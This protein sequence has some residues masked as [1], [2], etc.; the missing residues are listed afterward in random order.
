MLPRGLYAIADV[1]CITR[2]R[3]E[4]IPFVRALLEARPA[5]LQVRA[6][7]LGARDYLALL[8]TVVPLAKA[9][10]VTL[11]ANDRPDLAWL[12]GCDGVH[13]GQTDLPV[14]A[15]RRLPGHL[16]VGVSTHD[17]SQ[18]SQAF[19]ER[20]SYVAVGPVY[21]T[22]SK[23]NPEATVGL[24]LLA[25]AQRLSVASRIPLV[26]IGGIDAARVLEVRG[27]VQYV[28]VISALLPKDGKLST[29]TRLATDLHRLIVEV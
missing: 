20:P 17:A 18:L 10:S 19:A 26:A 24:E 9:A 15:V 23:Q 12:S 5:C 16:L 22:A 29:V 25:E 11:F 21:D 1:E 6:K 7:S 14:E 27:Y 28:A 4:V 2:A 8:E 13:V 3:F